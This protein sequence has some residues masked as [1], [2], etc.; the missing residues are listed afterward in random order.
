MAHP[1]SIFNF[2]LL[3]VIAFVLD[4]ALG[5]P[6]FVPHPI[7]WIG[8]A[9]TL[10]ERPLRALAAGPAGP[11]QRVP[12]AALVVVIAGGTYV[13][14]WL[15]L[16][17]TQGLSKTLFYLVSIYIIW[18]SLSVRSLK[19]EA[20]SVLAA[21]R[22]GNIEEGRRRLS[23]IVGRDTASLGEEDIYRAVAE[24]VAEN[25]SD[26]VVAPLFYLALGGPALMLAYKAVNTLDSMVGYKNERYRKFGW[27]AARLDDIAN[28]APARITAFLMAVSAFILGYDWR[29]ALDMVSRDGA[30]HSSP[31]AGLPEA[32]VAGA[33]GV[34]F[35]GPM[36][37][38]AAAEVKPFIG[39]GRFE[40]SPGTV[41]SSIRILFATALMAMVMACLL[42]FFVSSMF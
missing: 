23:R 5:D 1:L 31:N 10:V 30:N 11:E 8:R 9:I 3:L 33:I 37:Y 27:C 2:L 22:E 15:S 28:F 6:A 25:T 34:R 19:A 32:A 29:G 40:H 16:S 14:A 12:G 13:L 36:S 26:G 20:R 7:R 4:M 18:M 39:D 35:G 17:L 41:E 42:R 38:G 24:T 21:M